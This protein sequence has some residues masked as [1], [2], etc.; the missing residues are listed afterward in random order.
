MRNDIQRIAGKLEKTLKVQKESMFLQQIEME[1]INEQEEWMELVGNHRRGDGVLRGLLRTTLERWREKAL[2]PPREGKTID[3]ADEFELPKK[4]FKVDI[5]GR[6]ERKCSDAR[7]G[8]LLVSA[9]PTT[10][11]YKIQN[12]TLEYSLL[13]NGAGGC[14]VAPPIEETVELSDGTRF[15]PAAV[16]DSKKRACTSEMFEDYLVTF[17]DGLVMMGKKG[18]GNMNA[19]FF[20]GQGIQ[21]SCDS[22][23]HTNPLGPPIQAA[24]DAAKNVLY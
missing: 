14:L 20:C 2:L 4:T 9:V 12:T 5:I 21:E 23:L 6:E 3:L 15:S 16:W 1:A 22:H 19:T 11:C 17:K 8:L 24:H 13:L 10:R 7:L 18:R